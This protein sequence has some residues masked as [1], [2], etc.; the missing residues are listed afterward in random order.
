MYP[1]HSLKIDSLFFPALLFFPEALCVLWLW[2]EHAVLSVTPATADD[3]SHGQ[4]G[5]TDS[6]T[7]TSPGP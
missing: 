3:H 4:H 5:L 1:I 6:D 7:L 2:Q